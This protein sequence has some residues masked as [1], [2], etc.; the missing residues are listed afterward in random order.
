MTVIT[1]YGPTDPITLESVVAQGDLWS[2]LE[3]S[4]TVDSIGKT[5]LEE[6]ERGRAM[7]LIG[8]KER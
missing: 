8:I 5:I 2:P 3:S 1:P 4:V 7:S 6:E